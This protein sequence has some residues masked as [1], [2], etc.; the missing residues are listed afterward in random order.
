MYFLELWGGLEYPSDFPKLLSL[1][2]SI[3][4]TLSVA[5]PLTI[6]GKM[7]CVKVDPAAEAV[8]F[9]VLLILPVQS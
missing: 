9:P 1:F 4:H 3:W 6:F 5:S 8:W 7:A 2:N